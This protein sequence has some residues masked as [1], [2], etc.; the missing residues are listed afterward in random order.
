MALQLDFFLRV[1]NIYRLNNMVSGISFKILQGR[2]GEG[3]IDETR[4]VW[5][6]D[7]WVCRWVCIEVVGSFVLFSFF[8]CIY[9]KFSIREVK[10]QN[11]K[12][13]CILYT[14]WEPP[15]MNCLTSDGI[16]SVTIEVGYGS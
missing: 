9:L 3:D 10:N 6:D 11:M 13:S 2:Q 16:L 1:W 4:W 8:L 15:T 7:C 12:L 14:G 5:V